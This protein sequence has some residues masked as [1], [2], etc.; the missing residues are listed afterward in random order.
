MEKYNLNTTIFLCSQFSKSS[1]NESGDCAEK[2][3]ARAENP[4]PVSETG[5]GLSARVNGLKT[6]CN[7]YHFFQPGLKKKKK[8]ATMRIGCVFAS[9]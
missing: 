1:K 5:L 8:N 6:P 9:Q 7:R 3:S 2:V 4:S